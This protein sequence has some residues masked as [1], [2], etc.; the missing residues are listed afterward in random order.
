M[1]RVMKEVCGEAGYGDKGGKPT[2]PGHGKM[3]QE[4]SHEFK[5][6]LCTQCVSSQYELQHKTLSQANKPTSK[7]K[8]TKEFQGMVQ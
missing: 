5:D 7:Q 6:S 8:Q 2:I 3:G 1:L 4:D